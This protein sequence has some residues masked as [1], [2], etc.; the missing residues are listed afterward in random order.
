MGLAQQM[1]AAAFLLA[2]R[3]RSRT[4]HP[5]ADPLKAAR[6]LL[7][8]H[9]NTAEGEAFRRVLETIETGQ[10]EFREADIWLFSND[11]MPL[12]SALIE[13]RLEGR[14]W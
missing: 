7:A 13:A 10:G 5:C 14:L 4:V 9:G 1:N 3:R 6:R 12:V 2:L 8:V 11:T